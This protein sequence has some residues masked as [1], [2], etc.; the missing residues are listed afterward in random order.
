MYM[1]IFQRYLYICIRVYLS[2]V[3]MYTH[4]QR[5]YTYRPIQTH[6][7]VKLFSLLSLSL[8]SRS[9]NPLTRDPSL[10]PLPAR[11][12][13]RQLPQP[14]S[15]HPQKTRPRVPYPPHHQRSI[16]RPATVRSRQILTNGTFK[17][18]NERG[19][20]SDLFKRL[21]NNNNNEHFEID[22]SFL[23]VCVLFVCFLYK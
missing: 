8:F 1:C 19:Q 13:N 21:K 20:K 17:Q 23:G 2:G 7:R 4:T 14:S 18:T 22:E 11:V 10:P 6:P 12:M 9:T 16:T 3:C 15:L 5:L